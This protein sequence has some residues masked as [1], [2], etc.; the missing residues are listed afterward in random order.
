MFDPLPWAH[1][2]PTLLLGVLVMTL[3][4]CM[5]GGGRHSRW[6]MNEGARRWTVGPIQG[7]QGKCVCAL[8]PV[9]QHLIALGTA[10]E[11]TLLVTVLA[12]SRGNRQLQVK[13]ARCLMQEP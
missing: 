2:G 12:S 9:P 11:L 13:H 10:N 7:M 3:H 5:G 1:Q 6:G 4:G 8:F